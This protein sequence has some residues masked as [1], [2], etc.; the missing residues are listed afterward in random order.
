MPPAVHAT[1][2][3]GR[4]RRA[5]EARDWPDAHAALVEADAAAPLGPADLE[6]L[7]AAAYLVGRE[8]ESLRALERAHQA[9]AD[10]GDLRAA[11]RTAIWLCIHLTLRRE[12]GS[13]SGW[14]SRATRLLEREPGDCVE[15]GWV[16]M[17][18]VLRHGAA[19]DWQ[20]AHNLAAEAEGIAQRFGDADLLAFAFLDEG[21]ALAEMGRFDDGLR[22]LD[23]AMVAVTTGE[24]S[25]IVTGLVY[26]SVIESCQLAHDI[27]RAREWTTALAAWCDEQPGLVPFTSTCLIHRAEILQHQGEWDGALGEAA[28]A[29]RR[30]AER[31]WPW[32]AA[33]ATYR[34]AEIHRLQGG[35]AQ[36]EEA[37]RE[38]GRGGC[39][40]QPGLS[41]LRLA[42]GEPDA[43][44][45]GIRRALAEAAAGTARARL[46]PAAVEILLATG[47][48]PGARSA[49]DELAALAEGDDGG[50]LAA[51]VAGARGALEL[52]EDDARC[53]LVSLRRAWR[54]W[55]ELDA[56]YEAARVR[57]LVA[58]ACRSLGD[59]E[60]ASIELDA[61]RETFRL[62]GAVPDLARAE[63]RG[64]RRDTHGLTPREVEVLRLLAA[65]HSN[66]VIATH[67]VLSERTVERH[68][69]NI[70]AK[71]GASSRAGAT[72]YA[73]EHGLI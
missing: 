36:A 30:F 10:A 35:F 73:Y 7:A 37:Y 54:I 16:L 34:I 68:V 12:A 63:P 15:R 26:C 53:A 24:L 46:L 72:A 14:L 1:G 55:Q 21:R 6:L 17:P 43:A 9:W 18:E 20:A 39:E 66:K 40:P 65:G 28:L 13:A 22:L 44:A 38:A 23:E 11:A 2:A 51:H 19:G 67:L 8:D 59:D 49:C 5:F 60:A 25:P 56:P 33:E 29:G 27:R 62:L 45:A 4:G 42:R 70:L 3:L 61:A 50:L 32:A 31:G 64:E 41:L 57:E 48:T 58:E 47:D 69:S 52:A 71:L